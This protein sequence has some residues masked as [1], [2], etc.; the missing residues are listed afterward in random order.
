[1]HM[2][3]I[4]HNITTAITGEKVDRRNYRD[5]ANQ[6]LVSPED[7]S[8]SGDANRSIEVQTEIVFEVEEILNPPKVHIH[9]RALEKVSA[10][11]S[12]TEYTSRNTGLTNYIQS[13]IQIFWGGG[14]GGGGSGKNDVHRAMLAP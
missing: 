3:A 13:F 7:S 6:Y 10:K 1:M 12:A 9:Q 14:G 2:T 11:F 8:I 5:E 4:T